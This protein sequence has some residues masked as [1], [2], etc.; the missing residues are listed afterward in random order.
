MRR[1]EG[2]FDTAGLREALAELVAAQQRLEENLAF[3]NRTRDDLARRWPR[4]GEEWTAVARLVGLL[5][6]LPEHIEALEAE[7]YLQPGQEAA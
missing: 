5:D 7:C 4:L 2:L 1:V 3:N 6:G